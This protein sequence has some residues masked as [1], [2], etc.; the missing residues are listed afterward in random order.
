MGA[1]LVLEY[2]QQGTRT[3][4]KTGFYHAG[5]R[6]TVWQCYTSKT[7]KASGRPGLNRSN[8][9][10]DSYGKLTV[11]ELEDWSEA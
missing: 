10:A 7:A 4:P 5:C 6:T 1:I 11:A 9:A 2:R 8:L 3:P